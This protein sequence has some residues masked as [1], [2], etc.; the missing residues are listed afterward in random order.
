MANLSDFNVVEK[1]NSGKVLELVAYADFH[2]KSGELLISKGEVLT[3]EGEKCGD[4]KKVKNWYVK[5]LGVDSDQ[6]RKLSNRRMERAQ[7]KKSK[8]K[9]YRSLENYAGA[10][11]FTLRR[12]CRALFS[13]FLRYFY[14]I[15]GSRTPPLIILG[16]T[17]YPRLKFTPTIQS[18]LWK[19][20]TELTS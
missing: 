7:G 13:Q 12:N 14:C 8:K 20:N 6:F 2:D 11:F 9:N 18:T 15:L 10:V 17:V 5:L 16:L 1:A 19:M 4:K 3:D